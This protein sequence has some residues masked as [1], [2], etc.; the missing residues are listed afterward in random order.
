MILRNIV[1]F[2]QNIVARIPED[3]RREEYVYPI[4]T[5][6]ALLN[7]NMLSR[8]WEESKQ[9]KRQRKC[10]RVAVRDRRELES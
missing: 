3:S 8:G 5:P 2:Y 4:Q 6:S 10:E 1:D 9:E 7:R